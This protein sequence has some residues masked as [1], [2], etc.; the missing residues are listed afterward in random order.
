LPDRIVTE[1]LVLR[2]WR[3]D[4]AALLKN[5]I[6]S[7][8][9]DL[10]QWMPWALAEPTPVD[11]IAARLAGFAESFANDREWLYGVFDPDERQVLGGCGLHP[12]GAADT[13]EIGYWVRSSHTGRGYAT[14]AAGAVTRAAFG[15]ATINTVEIH[16]D[17]LNARS[18][19]IPRRLGYTHVEPL[20]GNALTPAGI[21]RDTMVWRRTREHVRGEGLTR[22]QT[23]STDTS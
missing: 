19:A 15:L 1:R 2:A 17:V 5:A 3:S 23:H 10:R 14:E 9:D 6:D 8:L 16:C 13:V 20:R 11:G 18:S 22:D 7:S 12:R 21:L 4:D